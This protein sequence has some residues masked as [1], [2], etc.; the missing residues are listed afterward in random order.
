VNSFIFRATDTAIR[1]AEL[2]ATEAGIMI[3]GPNGLPFSSTIGPW[4]WHNPSMAGLPAN[5][6]TPRTW[7]SISHK[8]AG[9]LPIETKP[10]GHDF[11]AAQ[12]AVRDAT[13]REEYV[14]TILTRIWY[15][16]DARPVAEPN[17]HGRA[18]DATT[19]RTY[20]HAP[21]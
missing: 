11:A 2:A 4:L 19:V 3:A 17:D 14:A 15:N 12:T 5:D 20:Q 10:S 13:L 1:E 18:L 21:E 6:G 9:G 8:S 16:C 7:F